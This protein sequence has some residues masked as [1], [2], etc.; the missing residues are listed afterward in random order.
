MNLDGEIT[1]L[2]CGVIRNNPSRGVVTPNIPASQLSGCCD[3]TLKVFADN[4]GNETQNDKSTIIHCYDSICSSASMELFKRV[5]GAWVSMSSITDN[6]YGTFNA[7]GYFVNSLSQ[8]FISFEIDWSLVLAAFG[9]GNFKVITTSN[10][11]IFGTKTVDS[12]EYCLMT[13]SSSLADGQVRLEYWLSGV[14]GDIEDDTL[15]KDFGTL[16][17]Y[18]SLRLD[19]FFGYPKAT[20]KEDRIEYNTGK[21]VYVEDEQTPVFKLKLSLIPFVIHEI[22]RTDFMMADELAITD[23]N[24]QNNAS[25]VKKYVVK[26]SGYDPKWYELKSNFASIELEFKQQY[27]RFRKLR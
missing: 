19:G 26:N 14:T 6:T 1:Y 17:V 12:Y 9:E 27:N 13:Y 11:S 7:F 15:Y 3:F 10:D 23:Y 4:T 2:N 22:L 21:H 8:K 18:N 20:Y 5:S 24:S 25:Y 16:S